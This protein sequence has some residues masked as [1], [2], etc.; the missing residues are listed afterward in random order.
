VINPRLQVPFRAAAC[1]LLALTAWW[2]FRWYILA[3]SEGL[4]ATLL[5]GMIGLS[6][7]FI[8]RVLIR[9]MPGWAAFALTAAATYAAIFITYEQSRRSFDWIALIYFENDPQ[10]ISVGIPMA[11]MIAL[12]ANA[13]ALSDDLRQ[14]YRQTFT[15]RTS[16]RPAPASI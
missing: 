1:A 3:L 4:D 7:G 15:R 9:A 12:G 5:L 6:I 16:V 10:V 11:L 2:L 13:Q 8:A 14:L